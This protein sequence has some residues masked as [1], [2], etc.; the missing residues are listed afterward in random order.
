M[1]NRPSETASARQNSPSRRIE[2][3]KGEALISPAGPT[4]AVRLSESCVGRSDGEII[5]VR[6]GTGAYGRAVT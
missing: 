3:K 4:N 6:R 5:H 1:P 2:K